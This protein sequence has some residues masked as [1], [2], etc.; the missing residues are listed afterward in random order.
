[1]KRI[2]AVMF[3]TCLAMAQLPTVGAETSR[4]SDKD[5]CLLYS[6]NCANQTLSIQEKIARLK[7][8]I[9][10]GTQVYSPAELQRLE[11]KLKEV[12]AILDDLLYGPSHNGRGHRHHR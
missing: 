12:E 10:K 8:E 1:M 4:G 7:E 3:F 2:I 11:D 5:L 6:Q 9:T